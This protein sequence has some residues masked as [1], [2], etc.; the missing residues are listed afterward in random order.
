MISAMKQ[1]LRF[2]LPR[3]NNPINFTQF[4]EV[5]NNNKN[6]SHKKAM[7]TVYIVLAISTL[8]VLLTLAFFVGKTR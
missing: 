1:S 2:H 6:N 7:N 3:L 4:I 8:L 5:N